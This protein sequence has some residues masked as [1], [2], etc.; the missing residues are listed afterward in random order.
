MTPKKIHIKQ[1]KQKIRS[2]VL[3]IS[4]KVTIEVYSDTLTVETTVKTDL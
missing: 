4:D 1:I 2:N 3:S